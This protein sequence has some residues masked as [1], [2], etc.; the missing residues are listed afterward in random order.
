MCEGTRWVKV[1][2]GTSVEDQVKRTLRHVPRCLTSDGHDAGR[3][4]HLRFLRCPR[5]LKYMAD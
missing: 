1:D 2:V 4:V 5:T 3:C